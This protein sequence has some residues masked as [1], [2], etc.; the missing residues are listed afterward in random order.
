R[1]MDLLS[2]PPRRSSD[3]A[4]G[5]VFREASDYIATLGGVVAWTKSREATLTAQ[6]A[7][8]EEAIAKTKDMS[9]ANLKTLGDVIRGERVARLRSEEHTSELQSREN[10][11]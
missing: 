10:L 9:I 3:L 1:H 6:R 7:Q 2:F 4:G 11:V 5:S 8:W